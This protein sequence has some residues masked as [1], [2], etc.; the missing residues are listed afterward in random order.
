MRK[1]NLDLRVKAKV[2]LSIKWYK[3]TLLQSSL[4]YI[5]LI[6]VLYTST[7]KL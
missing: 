5:P 2:Y 7:L 3:R 6:V 4:L 1:N